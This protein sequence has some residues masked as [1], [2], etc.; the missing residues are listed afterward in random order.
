MR[1]LYE[2]NAFS[3]LN[4]QISE[5]KEDI[6]K[7]DQKIDTVLKLCYETSME[8]KVLTEVKN[9][10]RRDVDKLT[11]G[12]EILVSDQQERT[13][14]IK[15]IK[16]LFTFRNAIIFFVGFVF[17]TAQQTNGLQKKSLETEQLNQNKILG[18]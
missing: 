13:G 8:V 7:L 16:T 1:D 14:M 12:A 17:A 10:L 5:L 18:N 4:T 2:S 11:S 15:T 6:R 3:W 9:T